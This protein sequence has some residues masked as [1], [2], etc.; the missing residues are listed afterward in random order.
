MKKIILY[1]IAFKSNKNKYNKN[2][3][4]FRT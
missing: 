3:W 2:L 1:F 4:R